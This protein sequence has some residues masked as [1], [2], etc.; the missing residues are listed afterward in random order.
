[1]SDPKII[2]PNWTKKLSENQ[3]QRELGRTTKQL[4]RIS[5][6]YCQIGAAIVEVENVGGALQ[7]PLREPV[8]CDA[9]KRHFKLKIR[10]KLY[11]EQ[12]NGS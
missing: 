11:G 1:M 10:V 5:C 4:H 12:I 7:F 8:K 6:P 9:C 3:R 2:V